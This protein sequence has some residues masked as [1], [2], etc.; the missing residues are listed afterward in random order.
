MFDH[1][2][3][4]GD[5]VFSKITLIIV[6]NPTV[7]IRKYC[8]VRLLIQQGNLGFAHGNNLGIKAAGI[9]SEWIFAMN[10]MSIILL[11]FRGQGQVLC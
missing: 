9:S 6:N 10:L 5:D 8:N 7:V 11:A 2:R 1:L 3:S 4:N